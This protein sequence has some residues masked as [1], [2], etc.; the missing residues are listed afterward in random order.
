MYKYK[1]INILKYVD[2]KNPE[3]EIKDGTDLFVNEN[4]N[5]DLY[6]QINKGRYSDALIV[7][8]SQFDLVKCKVFDWT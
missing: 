7:L 5:G 6:I 4:E 3:W 1:C 2:R 8:S